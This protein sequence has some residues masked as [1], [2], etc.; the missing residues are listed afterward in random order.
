MNQHPA[1]VATETFVK[2]RLEGE[3]TGHDW[4]HAVRVRNTAQALQ[5]Q[6]GGDLAIIELAALLHDVGDRKVIGTEHDDYTIAEDFL[7]R[8]AVDAQTIAHVM[9]IIA[10]MSY[11]KS[12]GSDTKPSRNPL[13]FR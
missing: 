7:V 11:S 1:I 9:H 8:Q 6:E 2:S 5:A 4:W 13:N 12:L 10:N 3:G